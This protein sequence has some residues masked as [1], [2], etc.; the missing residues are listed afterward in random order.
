MR[1]REPAANPK[2][3]SLESRTLLSVLAAQVIVSS[4][5]PPNVEDQG[6]ASDAQSE[7]KTEGNIDH[8]K[9]S[10][11]EHAQY[12]ETE[13]KGGEKG[14]ETEKGADH[15]SSP[16]APAGSQVHD[17]SSMMAMPMGGPGMAMPMGGPVGFTAG[18]IAALDT[19]ARGQMAGM[20]AGDAASASSTETMLF[21][22]THRAMPTDAMPSMTMIRPSP[23]GPLGQAETPGAMANAPMGMG[24]ENM[25]DMPTDREV[26]AGNL[27]LHPEI[28]LNME[29]EPSLRGYLQALAKGT[30]PGDIQAVAERNKARDSRIATDDPDDST[31]AF[32]RGTPPPVAEELAEP[33]SLVAN[34]YEEPASS[35]DTT[36]VLIGVAAALAWVEY[37]KVWLRRSRVHNRTRPQASAEDQKA[38]SGV[39]V[40]SPGECPPLP[41]F[42]GMGS[43]TEKTTGQ[44]D[45]AHKELH[46]ISERFM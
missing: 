4:D 43:S 14:G 29:V 31:E 2:L 39:R 3:C 41:F 15:V 42:S 24:S 5:T 22:S 8:T 6:S 36:T 17:E 16:A 46:E 19:G 13:D 12:I 25:S 26:L 35:A 1:R 38:T 30:D 10:V 27:N 18:S 9:H 33:S 21:G 40:D 44:A 11:T 7:A 34:E 23:G 45:T 37:E 28:D 20:A 32:S